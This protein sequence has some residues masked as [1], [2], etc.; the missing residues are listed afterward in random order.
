MAIFL[1]LL[2]AF[3]AVVT[4]ADA[5]SRMEAWGYCSNA[6][7][8]AHVRLIKNGAFK[9][10]E[11]LNQAKIDGVSGTNSIM[12][13]SKSI[14]LLDSVQTIPPSA[15]K[16]YID[17]GGNAYDTSV[18]KWFYGDGVGDHEHVDSLPRLKH[19]EE[20]S[21]H[22]FEANPIFFDSYK[23]AEMSLPEEKFQLHKVAAW[24]AN[25]TL[26]FCNSNFSG[27][28]TQDG[29]IAC[30]DKIS[31]PAIDFGTWILSNFKINDFV[32]LKFDIEGAEHTM[33]PLLYASG[34]MSL[35]DELLLECHYEGRGA[36]KRL[37]PG[38]FRH[39]CMRLI[40]TLRCLGVYTHEWF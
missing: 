36:G 15:K 33:M 23:R 26:E 30:A 25:T 1:Q 40:E 22:V 27:A 38:I 11:K 20:Y 17:V 10:L 18:G 3:S 32:V 4:L 28:A 5:M 13:R 2:L 8:D 21:V 14:V 29:K 39:D 35:V 19:P 6:V 24:T 7:K 37:T 31:V 34:A 9:Y 12:M 16:V